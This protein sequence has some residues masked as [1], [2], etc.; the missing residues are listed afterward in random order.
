MR[1]TNSLWSPVSVLIA[2]CILGS[3]V[4]AQQLKLDTAKIEEL[5][6]AKGAMNEKEGVFK[7][8]MPRSDLNVTSNGVKITPA[9]GLTCWAAF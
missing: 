8:S 1:T 2:F 4:W 3:Q 9:M 5:T 7:V 6:G